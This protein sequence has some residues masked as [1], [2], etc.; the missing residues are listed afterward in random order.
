MC[1]CVYSSILVRMETA[2]AHTY[3]VDCCYLG[4]NQGYNVQMVKSIT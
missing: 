4:N 1:V 2:D 3:V